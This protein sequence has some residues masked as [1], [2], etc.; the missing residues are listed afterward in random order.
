MKV[1]FYHPGLILFIMLKETRSVFDIVTSYGQENNNKKCPEISDN[2]TV[3][4]KAVEDDKAVTYQ[5]LRIGEEKKRGSQSF[6]F[7]LLKW[8]S[9]IIFGHT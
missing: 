9:L 5:E 4:G 2:T 6:S 8:V 7:S 3:L 1:V